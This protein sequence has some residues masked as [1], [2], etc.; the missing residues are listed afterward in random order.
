[1]GL[2]SLTAQRHGAEEPL[3]KQGFGAH[4]IEVRVDA[5]TGEVRVARAIGV[6]AA[7]RILNAKTARSQFIGGMTMGISMALLEESRMDARTCERTRTSSE[8]G[9]RQDIR[10]ALF[11]QGAEKGMARELALRRGRARKAA[12]EARSLA[13]RAERGW[14]L[15]RQFVQGGSV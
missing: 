15:G 7:G 9:Q 5:D 8:L 10:E 6:F 3:A 13:G 11:G 12:E 14:M 1:M 2:G 4:V